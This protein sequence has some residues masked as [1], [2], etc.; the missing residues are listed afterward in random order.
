MRK[1]L[2]YKYIC[3]IIIGI[4][5]I[6]FFANKDLNISYDKVI[7]AEGFGYYVYLPAT[8][9]YHDYTFD[10]F[11]QV[12]PK[13]YSPSYNPPTKN[14]INEFDGI[15]VNK[16]YPGVSLLWTPFFLLALLFAKLLHLPADGFSDIFQ[17]AIGVAGLFYTWLGLKYLKKIL[18]H[19]KHSKAALIFTLIAVAFA[20]NLLY[21]VI[22]F[23]S[24]THSYLFFLI[25]AFCY[26]S[27]KLFD[28][29][30]LDKKIAIV[31]VVLSLALIATVR[32]QDGIVILLLPFFGLTIPKVKAL[33]A[34]YFLSARVIIAITVGLLIIARVCYYWYLQTGVF[35]LNPYKGRDHFNFGDP[36][37]I[38][39]LFSYRKGWITYSPIILFAFVGVAFI[40][41]FIKKLYLTVF[42]IILIYITSSWWCWTYSPTSF[43]QRVFVDF[44][45]LIGISIGALFNYFFVRNKRLVPYIILLVFIPIS[46][47]QAYQYKL[48]IIHGD[49]E[50]KE[51][52]WKNYFRTK[53]LA[54]YP[55]P[56]S[57]IINRSE[58]ILDFENN[59]SNT[60]L[61]MNEH[62]SGEWATFITKENPFSEGCM[63]TLPTFIKDKNYSHL[64][65]NAMIKSSIN[66][67]KEVL[68]LDFIKDGKSVSWNGFDISTYIYNTKWTYYECGLNIPTGVNP[69]DTLNFYFW[70]AEGTDT[71]YIDNVK[72]EFVETDHSYDFD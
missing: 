21:Y 32:P 50:T 13:Y 11:N 3:E 20:T 8:F 34:N 39:I 66:T 33:F 54:Q 30:Y 2:V 16:Y 5:A 67:S 41:K 1:S 60:K 64:R 10:F 51:A 12:Y 49:L 52:F 15:K 62:Y 19:L 22:C 47:L 40:G 56:E 4:A 37:F 27:F 71:T 72:L 35:F 28:D 31:G 43:G 14:F 17:Y 6:L 45:A 61:T 9:I 58:K 63:L 29:E 59:S 48:G 69:G 25:A 57:S 23:P 42:W 53:P 44:Y 18:E 46:V 68:V 70:Q 24:Q 65:V 26:Y 55:I 36:Y 7:I 38:D